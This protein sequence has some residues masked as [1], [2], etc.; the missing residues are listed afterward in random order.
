MEVH[1]N[2]LPNNLAQSCFHVSDWSTQSIHA[3]RPK[4]QRLSTLC[5]LLLIRQSACVSSYCFVKCWGCGCV[6]GWKGCFRTCSIISLTHLY[7]SPTDPRARDSI[8]SMNYVHMCTHSVYLSQ[9]NQLSNQSK[10]LA[11]ST[12]SHSLFSPRPGGVP[13]D[14]L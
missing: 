6:G 14:V 4:G 1:I 7:V 10:Q 2:Q 3:P 8:K 9:S 12:L 11:G 5:Q 13:I